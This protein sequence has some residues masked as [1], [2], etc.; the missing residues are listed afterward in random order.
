MQILSL[1]LAQVMFAARGRAGMHPGSLKV[2]SLF[3]QGKFKQ[4]D[5]GNL[6]IIKKKYG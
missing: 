2:K 1:W 6:Y 5:F 3:F 4:R